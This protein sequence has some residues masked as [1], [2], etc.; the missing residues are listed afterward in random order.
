MNYKQLLI[1]YSTPNLE[2]SLEVEFKLLTND[3][4]QCWAD[5]VVAAQ[6]QYSIDDP[7]RFYGFGSL[8]EQIE[9]SIESINHC[10]DFIENQLGIPVGRRLEYIHD[11]DTLNYF[12]HI[13][14]V[15]HGLLDKQHHNPE[16][17]KVLS[18]LNVL[19]HRCESVQ[20]GAA[21]RHVVTYFGLP[22][23]QQLEIE[24][25]D[26]FTDRYRFGTV[27]LNY[28]EIGK[29]LEDLAH[30]N[31]RYI[32]Q[33]AFKP[34]RHFSADFNVKFYDT[35][36]HEQQLNR[37]KIKEF[38]QKNLGFFYSRGLAENHPYLYPGSVPLA[39]VETPIDLQDLAA[40]RWVKRVELH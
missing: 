4:V 8:S 31:D 26:L 14:E 3:I 33:E 11:Q 23:T 35:S 12:H 1:E 39:V 7:G 20:R 34:F 10:V 2:N 27:Y 30:D 6:K 9:F 5:R 24:D 21:P 15:H 32:S 13:F 29:T 37:Q 28:A 36:V 25:Y 16:Y 22:K 40:R 19:V 38:Y 17:N 18:N